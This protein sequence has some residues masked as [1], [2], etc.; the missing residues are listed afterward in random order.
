[1][2]IADSASATYR[3]S[4]IASEDSAVLRFSRT[5][6]Y[7]GLSRIPTVRET[8]NKQIRERF[9]EFQND[10]CMENIRVQQRIA[11]FILRLWQRQK[12][13][14]GLQIMIPT[15][16]KDIAQRLGTH[17]ETVIRI[18]S[19]WTKKGWIKTVDKRIVIMNIS[20][21]K[22]IRDDKSHKN[23]KGSASSDFENVGSA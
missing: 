13:E 12:A 1:M 5:F 17:T 16:R 23:I 22:E 3:A 19:Q 20:K 11:D 15:T 9:L 7:D 6:F 21:L 4:A 2:A 10:R 8:V 18:L 14:L